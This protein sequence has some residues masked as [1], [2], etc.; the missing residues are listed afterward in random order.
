MKGPG[1][2]L[3]LLNVNNTDLRDI[4]PQGMVLDEKYDEWAQS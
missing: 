2:F 3:E 1:I 4:S